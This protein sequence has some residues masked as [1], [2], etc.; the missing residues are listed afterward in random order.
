[1]PTVLGRRRDRLALLTCAV[2]NEV[3]DPATGAVPTVG[4]RR[5]VSALIDT[6]A[7][8]SL[9]DGGIASALRLPADGSIPLVFPNSE[10]P[11][12]R[13]AFRGALSLARDATVTA[14]L[15]WPVLVRLASFAAGRRPF[16]MILGM[17]ILARGDLTLEP[18]RAVTF[19]FDP[20]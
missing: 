17:D 14:S 20:F 12:L 13:P 10:A 3:P 5:A 9:I 7:T 1:M 19:S 2:T 15:P 4:A 16:Q 8:V 18:S 6:G 11:E